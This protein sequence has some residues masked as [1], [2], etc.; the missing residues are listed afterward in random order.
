MT[1][2][3]KAVTTFQRHLHMPDAD[4]LIC[5]LGAVAA[6]N[7]DGDPVWLQVVGPPS[8]GKT[9]L[10]QAVASLPYVHAASTI[11]EAA[12]LSGTSRRE[13]AQDA[14][15]GLLREI[16]PYG[17]L[18]VKDFTSV[19]SMHR[20]A[21][22][23]VLAAL[24][25]VYDGTWTRRLG[26]D[27]GRTLHWSGKVGFIGACTEAIDTAHGVMSS[28]GER[29]VMLRLDEPD[30]EALVS[31]ALAGTGNEEIMRQELAQ[32][33]ADVFNE[34]VT[35]H[36]PLSDDDR[37]A[38]G[39]VAI[40][41]VRARSGQFRDGYTREVEVIPGAES[42][43]RLVKALERLYS[44]MR[45]IDVDETTAWRI[46]CRVAM[47]SMPRLRRELIRTLAG[48]PDGMGTRA[49][50]EA[51]GYPKSTV[52]RALSDLTVHKVTARA[53]QGQHATYALT[54][55]SRRGLAAFTERT[56]P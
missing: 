45:T 43:A 36:K 13:V 52:D 24:R 50:A 25:E 30:A 15:G 41:V 47:D 28:M 16:G 19:L 54:P 29:F 38:L 40:L 4:A 21:R 8:S 44:G 5:V 2:V 33:V 20:D 32:A 12:L 46:T 6:N 17:V 9:E 10:V 55:L 23:G 56:Q 31:V 49:L 35:I 48:V 1:A 34:Q 39:A 27:G 3:E 7:M 51:S 37:Q 18:L 14:N 26:T 53:G 42:P 22:A 11:T